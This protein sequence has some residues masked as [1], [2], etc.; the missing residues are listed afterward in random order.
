M[1]RHFL[2]AADRCFLVRARACAF[3]LADIGDAYERMLLSAARGERSLFV[4]AAELTEMWRIFTPLLHEIDAKRSAPTIHPFGMLPA[5]FVPWAARAGVTIHPTW[6]EFVATHGELIDEIVR[7]FS[8]LDG[9]C[10]DRRSQPSLD[11]W[12]CLLRPPDLCKRQRGPSAAHGAALLPRVA[13]P[14][15]CA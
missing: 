7:V 12:A 9:M 5:D 11:P 14:F 8:E 10:G 1:A 4:S 2:P 13:L 15:Y 3:V 6:K